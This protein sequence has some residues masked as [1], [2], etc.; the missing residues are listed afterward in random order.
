MNKWLYFIVVL[1][2]AYLR[3]RIIYCSHWEEVFQ[4]STSAK[5]KLS[6]SRSD[7]LWWI[8]PFFGVDPRTL[9]WKITMRRRARR[10]TSLVKSPLYRRHAH[11]SHTET[12][13]FSDDDDVTF[14][15]YN[16]KVAQR[17]WVPSNDPNKAANR[18]SRYRARDN[19]RSAC[20]QFCGVC[21]CADDETY[22]FTLDTVAIKNVEFQLIKN[23]LIRSPAEILLN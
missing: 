5:I 13:M 12:A 9:H 1:D 7:E 3:G 19:I 10:S 6:L 8:W 2:G 16:G 14:A 20:F 22:H 4:C 15:I 21:T 18:I 11:L 17:L 23:T